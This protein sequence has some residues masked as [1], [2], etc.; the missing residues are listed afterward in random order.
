MND[1]N[2]W[3]QEN[4][5]LLN[6]WLNRAAKARTAHRIAAKKHM[7]FHKWI[8]IFLCMT[9]TALGTGL[10]VELTQKFN[11]NWVNLGLGAITMILSYLQTYLNHNERAR[12]HEDLRAGFAS[13]CREIQISIQ[14]PPENN[15][16]NRRNVLS[17]IKNMYDE[18]SKKHTYIKE[19]Y[20]ELAEKEMKNKAQP[21]S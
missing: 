9:S 8:G 19:C 7:S 5:K 18:L 12:R 1:N 3:D 4:L 20:W 6:S 11:L 10:Y 13:L 21:V 17:N 2:C 15:N 14:C 16:E